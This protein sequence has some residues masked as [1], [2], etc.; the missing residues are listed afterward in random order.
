MKKK[1]FGLLSVT[2]IFLAPCS[3]NA[4][5]SS[6][7]GSQVSS[8]G[9]LSTSN[10]SGHYIPPKDSARCNNGDSYECG[11]Y[12]TTSGSTCSDGGSLC[13]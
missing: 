11:I 12:C 9:S 10:C 5:Y 13:S 1:L 3:S 7:S 2:F 4:S 6:C 8:C